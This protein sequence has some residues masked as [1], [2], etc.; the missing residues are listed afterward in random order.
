MSEI[1][2]NTERVPRKL[3]GAIYPFTEAE[4]NAANEAWGANCGPGALATM[5]SLHV[6]D[7]RAHLVGFD[8]KRYTNPTM[9]YG[10]LKALRI[11]YDDM[12]AGIGRAS[13]GMPLGPHELPDY[14]LTRI[15][16]EGPWTAEGANPKWAYRQT[17]WIGSYS[18][19]QQDL[20]DGKTTNVMYVYDINGGW[21]PQL[22]WEKIIVPVL[23]SLYPRST[24][25][26]HAK[27]RLELWPHLKNA[28]PK[29]WQR[30]QLGIPS[31]RP[32][33][34]DRTHGP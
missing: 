10:A 8:G 7:V 17:H 26:W 20:R 19:K 33:Q 5:L 2:K 14:G 34:P 12:K 30:E 24:G 21:R 32:P 31:P 9:M 4:F 1:I 15:Q 18:V 28:G 11:P 22:D 27:Q 25:G 3:E 13:N 23:T 29:E 6:N 16:W